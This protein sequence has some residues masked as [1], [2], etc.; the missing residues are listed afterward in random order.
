MVDYRRAEMMNY[1]LVRLSLFTHHV[2]PLL[3]RVGGAIDYRGLI[4]RRMK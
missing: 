3:L 1:R 2:S 4:N